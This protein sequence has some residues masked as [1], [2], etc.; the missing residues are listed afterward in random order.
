MI[1]KE[2]I[3]EDKTGKINEIFN[4]DNV[5]SHNVMHIEDSPNNRKFVNETSTVRVSI[6]DANKN[7]EKELRQD[8]ASNYSKKK[9]MIIIYTLKNVFRSKIETQD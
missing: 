8:T 3:E 5:D 4:G 9:K 6:K 7:G 1:E 2:N